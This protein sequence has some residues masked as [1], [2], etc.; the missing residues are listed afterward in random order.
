MESDAQQ[1]QS[2][3]VIGLGAEDATVPL[4]G[5]GQQSALVFLQA[6]DK[7]VVHSDAL[8]IL[9]GKKEE[10]SR[11][12]KDALGLFVL[13]LISGLLGPRYDARSTMRARRPGGRALLGR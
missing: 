6:E 8:S 2:V 5:L 1:V 12:K 7:L 4:D 10:G 13:S 3:G 11:M 9:K